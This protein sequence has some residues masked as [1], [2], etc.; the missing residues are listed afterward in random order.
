MPTELPV[1]YGSDMG[2]KLWDK[3][4][5]N[6]YL[7]VNRYKEGICYGCF[8]NKALGATIIDSCK[9]CMD[10]RGKEAI[11]QHIKFNYYGMCFFCGEYKF[12]SWQIN[13]RLCEMC[14][15][16]V[17]RILQEFNRKGG[18]FNVDPF[19]L[20]MKKKHGKDW[21]PMYGFTNTQV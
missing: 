15:L 16:R 14:H 4:Q 13:V 8:K 1:D 12:D 19:W 7:R 10:R 5:S 9:S 11:L 2:K 20:K 18:M 3:H 6:E 17:R 21:H